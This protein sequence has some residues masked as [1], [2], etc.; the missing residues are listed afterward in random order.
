M[1]F[2]FYSPTYLPSFCSFTFFKFSLVYHNG[3]WAIDLQA[4]HYT[5]LHCLPKCLMY[6]LICLVHSTCPPTPISFSEVTLLLL[7]L[8]CYGIFLF[9][10]SNGVGGR[11]WR[12]PSAIQYMLFSCSKHFIHLGEDRKIA[13]CDLDGHL[14]TMANE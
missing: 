13:S 2:P 10:N 11:E 3:C 1:A 7:L 12:E 4:Y 5:S 9:L 14:Y 6:F 8:A